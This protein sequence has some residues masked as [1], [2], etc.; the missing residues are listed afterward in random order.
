MPTTAGRPPVIVTVSAV[1]L[2][3]DCF[4]TNDQGR[5]TM[6]SIIHKLKAKGIAFFA[7]LGLMALTLMSPTVAIADPAKE[8]NA[9][10]DGFSAAYS[11]NDVEKL[12][13]I[14]APNT[15]LLGTNSPSIAEGRDAAR[16]YFTNLKLAGSGNKNA[17]QERR[18]IVLNDQAVLVTGFYEFTRMKDGQPVPAPARF[19]VLLTKQ[20]GKWL[21]AHQH[22]SPRAAPKN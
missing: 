19:T 9:A 8:A 15:I 12:A 11:A 13:L 1:R 7:L 17:I 16:A 22:S 3:A 5:K 6:K 18:T 4:E 14:Y 2:V 21:I 20:D 10:L